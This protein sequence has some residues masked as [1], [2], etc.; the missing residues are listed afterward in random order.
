MLGNYLLVCFFLSLSYWVQAQPTTVTTQDK[1]EESYQKRIRKEQLNG[2]YVPK[3]LP[4][5]FVHLNRLI[6][7]PSKQKFKN[8]P[9]DLAA[10]KL[11]YSFG[12][13]MIYNW[14]FYE[15]SRLSKSINEMGI[16]HP[17]DMAK[18]I[19][20]AYHRS[21]NKKALKIE[22]LIKT[23]K[24]KQEKEKTERLKQGTIIREETR[25]KSN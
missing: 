2:V 15:G 21:L 12:R 3:D 23:F 5:A 8:M 9:E 7:K 11:H 25:K 13:W 1:Y 20:I 18:F 24:E 19:I 16:Y 17:D 14:G 10:V 4:D 22:E 6:D